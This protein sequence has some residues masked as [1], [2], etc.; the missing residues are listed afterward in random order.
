MARKKPY[1][2]VL[3]NHVGEDVYE[4]LKDVDPKT[5]DFQ[6]TYDIKVATVLDE[7]NAVINALKAEGYRTRGVN[8]EENV[9]TLEKVLKRSKPDIIFNLVEHFRDDP[10]LEADVAAMFEIYGIAYTGATPFSL[11]L[12]QKKGLTKRILQ[13]AGIPTPH[14]K[15][16]FTVDE[17]DKSHGL[18][19][20][21]IVKPAREDASSG[22]EK[23]SVVYD[24]ETLIKRAAFALEEFSAPLLVEEFFAGMELHVGILGYDEPEMLPPIEW[25]FSQLPPDYPPLISY[26][27]KWNP[28]AEVYHRVHSV[29]PA[30]I[31]D[32][33]LARVEEVAIRAYEITE[34]RDYARLDIRLHDDGTPYVLE[35]NPNP[36]LTE[37]VS[38]ME[39]AEEAGYSFQETIG[40]IAEYAMER[41][42]FTPIKHT[43]EPP[44]RTGLDPSTAVRVEPPTDDQPPP[45]TDPPPSPENEGLSVP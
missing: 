40:Y 33:T 18:R 3:Y 31:T 16:I 20:P 2:I 15:R 23:D 4:S 27:A 21:V 13:A 29:C 32:D 7:Y 36:D 5:L 30:R 26:A 22:V 1:A 43:P 42:Q 14:F 35:V 8:L 24:F 39:A 44:L 17:I 38:F 12:C 45:P 41:R 25:D 34:C 11:S 6:P 37:G 28:L 9:R 10:D 19:Y